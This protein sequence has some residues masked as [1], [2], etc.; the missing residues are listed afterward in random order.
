MLTWFSGQYGAKAAE[1]VIME[2]SKCFV[3]K[4]MLCG[5]IDC[6]SG[7]I[8]V[9]AIPVRLLCSQDKRSGGN[10]AVAVAV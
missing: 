8:L 4:H 9:K 6:Y 5:G 10:E 3:W 2:A 7:V 1:L